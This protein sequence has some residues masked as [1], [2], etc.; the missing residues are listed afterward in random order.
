M[1]SALVLFCVALIGNSC[2]KSGSV[3]LIP[4]GTYAGTFQRQISNAGQISNVTFN[5]SA[6]NWTGKSQFVKYPALCNGTYKAK[7]GDSV[8]F[9]NACAWTAEFDWTLI[10]TGDYKIKITG[11]NIE[12]SREYNNGAVKDIYDLTKQ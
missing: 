4:D 5:F 1:K 6:G 11:N 2:K 3:Y 8:S 10:L 12:I 7:G 9:E